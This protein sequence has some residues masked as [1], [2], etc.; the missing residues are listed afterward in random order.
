M[1]PQDV[2]GGCTP[3][4]R[5]DRVDSVMMAAAMAR[6]ALTRMGPRVFGSR[7]RA[8]IRVLDAPDDR[9]DGPQRQVLV[10]LRVGGEPRGAEAGEDHKGEDDG[11]HDGHAM[12]EEAAPEQLP[13][14]ANDRFLVDELRSRAGLDGL[15][16][17]IEQ[18]PV[19]QG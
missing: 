7:W 15:G 16:G 12:A 2:V 14:R 4:P 13:L 8:M 11:R 10:V 1:R 3:N 5:N 17:D 9:P 6:V 19:R 18:L